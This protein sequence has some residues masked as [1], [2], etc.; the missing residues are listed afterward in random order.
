MLPRTRSVSASELSCLGEDTGDA[1]SPGRFHWY[2]EKIEPNG[3]P[4][5]VQVA[6]EYRA[7]TIRPIGDTILTCR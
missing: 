7:R 3:Y 6:Q 2:R 5:G 4:A 1:D